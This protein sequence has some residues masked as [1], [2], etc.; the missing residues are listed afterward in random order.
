MIERESRSGP[1]HESGHVVDETTDFRI[2]I[3]VSNREGRLLRPNDLAGE[4]E[5]ADRLDEDIEPNLGSQ[6][7][8]NARSIEPRSG[9]R[10]IHELA[11]TL[12]LTCR[13]ENVETCLK[14]RMAAAI[15]EVSR[16]AEL[17]L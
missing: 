5:G 10:N 8:L 11:R 14:S 7:R 1:H 4:F 6:L 17:L 15:H 3:A 12:A 16:W 13:A 9:P 2:E